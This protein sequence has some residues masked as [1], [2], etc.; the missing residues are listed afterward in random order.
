[1]T[2]SGRDEREIEDGIFGWLESPLPGHPLHDC[3]LVS[4]WAFCTHSP[5]V[6]VWLRAADTDTALPYGTRR[7]DVGDAYPSCGGAADSGFLGFVE[8]NREGRVTHVDVWC[9]LANGREVRLFSRRTARSAISNAIGFAGGLLSRTLAVSRTGQAP[10]LAA[11][12]GD[13]RTAMETTSK[14]ALRTLLSNGTRIRFVQSPSP[15]VSIVIVLWNRA[16]FTLRC[17]RA[18]CE[19]PDGFAEVV[20]VDNGSTDDTAAL[21]A[22]IDGARVVRNATNRGFPAGAN[23]GARAASGRYLLFLNNDAEMLP[24]A[25]EHLVRTLEEQQDAGAAGGKLVF[26]DGR[27]QEAG[28]IVWSDGSCAPYG[29]GASPDS[30]EFN[31]ERDVDY[32]S[33]A[34]LLT[35][36]DL[37]AQLGGFDERYSPAYYEDVDYCARLWTLGWR[38]VYQPMSAA[39]H[40]ESASSGSSATPLKLQV[41]HRPVFQKIHREWLASQFV[42][43]RDHTRARTHGA[44]RRTI[45]VIDDAWPDALRGSGLPRSA[46]IVKALVREGFSV[47]LLPMDG[48]VPV[49]RRAGELARVEV[50]PGGLARLGAALRSNQWDAVLVS[51]PHNMQHVKII[52][53]TD[54][55][56][57]GMPV[58]YD[59]EALYA[60]RELGR[61]AL[62]G[63]PASPED[64]ASRTQREIELAR[65]AS[66][67]LAVNDTEAA[68]F[69][70]VAQAPVVIV[71]HAVRP[72]P[73]PRPFAGR[74]GLLFVGALH[75][76]SPN[77][78]AVLFLVRDVMPEVTRL[79]G[80]SMPVTIIGSS[81]SPRVTQL[82]GSDVSVLADVADLTPYF[83]AARVFVAPTRYSSGIPLK[84]LQAAAHGLPSVA[85]PQL[86][87]Q[88][89][90]THGRDMLI[91]TTASDLAVEILRLHE[92]PQ[93]W[94]RVRDSAL[95]RIAHEYSDERLRS[96]VRSACDVCLKPTRTI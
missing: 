60:S 22:S 50:I 20:L 19:L 77:E 32:C 13:A 80:W 46:E 12:S 74:C 45:L 1:M 79:A 57:L 63:T 37:F 88:L 49:V 59:A 54:L 90:W 33:G 34:F 40:Y 21:L 56:K 69:R 36:C 10:S 61:L 58:I 85:T 68:S 31:F 27:L 17:L 29:R 72:A 9:V 82:S 51:R 73:T 47:S 96:A 16:E 5:I 42:A 67:V 30:P 52:G 92:D 35:R 75:A 44:S 11:R 87:Q 62:A 76:H 25:L 24:G 28:A 6:R 7:D 41:E 71:G 64:A 94:Q 95:E 14:L 84:I 23:Q 8:L 81:P 43:S 3:L 93:L 26:P 70:A 55:S 91:G 65:G 2:P 38:I 15:V 89:G 86:A 66:V 18:V 4:G 53:G 78:D 83:D 48:T 39:I